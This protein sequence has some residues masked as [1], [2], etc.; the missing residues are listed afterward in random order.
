MKMPETKRA[1]ET[2][3]QW[4][5]GC[6]LMLIAVITL[7]CALYCFH[8]TAY[9]KTYIDITSPGSRKL[10]IAIYDL[11][12]PSGRDIAE[13]IREDLIFTGLFQYID[14]ASYIESVT[15]PLN[16]QNWRP[17]GIEA[18]V[19]G[20]AVIDQDLRVTISVFDAYEGKELLHRQYRAGQN[21]LRQLA[22]DIANDI[23]SVF[24]GVEGVFRSKIAFVLEEE[25]S[26]SIAIMDWDG[27]RIRKMGLRSMLVL[28]PHWSFGGTKIIYSSERNRQWGLYLLDFDKMTERLI[29]STKGTTMTGGFFPGDDRIAFSSAVQGTPDLY[30]LTLK[31]GTTRRLTTSYGIEVSPSVSPD[32]TRIAFVSDRGGTPQIYTMRTDGGDIRRATFEG[33]YNTSPGWSPSGDRIAFTC[34]R[35]KNQICLIAPDGTDLRQLTEEGNNEDPSFSPDGRYVT[36]SSDR[37]GV[38]GIYIMRANGESQHRITPAGVKAAGPRWSPR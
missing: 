25:G 30:V 5:N 7:L 36:F 11:E 17:L 24:T 15:Q 14:K 18:V 3:N 38:K 1:G 29:F 34:R 9:A 26:K 31:D 16:P 32:G 28:S 33:S 19:K 4:E 20:S 2:R 6:G 22:H 10:P 35:G 27:N 13:I 12:G 23:Y 21:L 8:G 37:D